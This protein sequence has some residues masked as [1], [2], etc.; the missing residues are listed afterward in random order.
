MYRGLGELQDT[1]TR[2]KRMIDWYCHH[3]QELKENRVRHQAEALEWLSDSIEKWV[4]NDIFDDLKEQ[5]FKNGRSNAVSGRPFVLLSQHP[6]LC[7]LFKCAILMKIQQAGFQQLHFQGLVVATTQLYHAAQHGSPANLPWPDMDTLVRFHS[8]SPYLGSVAKTPVA[9][10]QRL[11]LSHGASVVMFA[12][13]RR[14]NKPVRAKAGQPIIFEQSPLILALYKRFCRLDIDEL[15]VV[16][17][18]ERQLSKRILKH[19]KSKI[20]R[21]SSTRSDRLGPVRLLV[22]LENAIA[23]EEEALYFDYFDLHRQCWQVLRSIEL[24]MHKD[25]RTWSTHKDR[26]DNEVLHLVPQFILDYFTERDLILSIQGRQMLRQAA[27]TIQAFLE[28][29][30]AQAN[31]AYKSMISEKEEEEYVSELSPATLWGILN[32]IP[33]KENDGRPMVRHATRNGKCIHVGVCGLQFSRADM[34]CVRITQELVTSRLEICSYS[35][36]NKDSSI[37]SWLLDIY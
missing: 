6:W 27:K 11:L 26:T 23:E 9:A 25:F 31:E 17:D 3:S 13:K 20:A 35:M 32:H 22:E 34:E 19:P 33:T 5:T 24:S 16:E 36:S 1:G 12:K 29:Q 21:N 30:E 14:T 15:I 10:Y 37:V 7:G 4:L 2:V 18:L 28:Q 8:K